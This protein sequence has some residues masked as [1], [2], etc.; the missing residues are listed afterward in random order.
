MNRKMIHQVTSYKG[1]RWYH[2]ACNCR[3][4]ET[5]TAAGPSTLPTSSTDPTQRMG[6]GTS[7]RSI[8][9]VISVLVIAQLSQVLAWAEP[10]ANS[11]P[12]PLVRPELERISV[13]TPKPR[14]TKQR[15][16]MWV[17]GCDNEPDVVSCS[18]L[19]STSFN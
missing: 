1:H 6:N 17:E 12:K 18:S 14:L 16:Q 7:H 13:P 10:K 9:D 15:K 11:L 3:L 5:A 2:K 19:G 4:H 8:N